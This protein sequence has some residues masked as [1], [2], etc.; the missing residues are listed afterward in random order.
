M[1]KYY[2][3]IRW[4]DH[5]DDDKFSD[6]LVRRDAAALNYACRMARELQAARGDSD[7]GRD[8]QRRSAP[9]GALNSFPGRLCLGLDRA[10]HAGPPAAAGVAAIKPALAAKMGVRRIARDLKV[11]VGTVLRLKAAY[12]AQGSSSGCHFGSAEF[13]PELC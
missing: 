10:K 1:P 2:F 3:T 13:N 7:P 9:H 8:R 4:V 11:G 5:V 12:V 6:H